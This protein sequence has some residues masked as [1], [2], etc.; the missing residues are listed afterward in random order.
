MHITVGT[1]WQK[2]QNYAIKY[3]VML[4]KEKSKLTK[5]NIGCLLV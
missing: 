3:K 2:S 4:M 5:N 1:I